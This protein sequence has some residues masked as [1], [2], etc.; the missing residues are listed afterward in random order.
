MNILENT[1]AVVILVAL[2]LFLLWLT[3]TV[4]YQM[5]KCSNCRRQAE[6]HGERYGGGIIPKGIPPHLQSKS[7]RSGSGTTL[8]ANSETDFDAHA[9]DVT[10][11]P[12][13][14]RKENLLAYRFAEAE[15][16]IQK[17][18]AITFRLH[19]KGGDLWEARAAAEKALAYGI[20][21][22]TGDHWLLARLL[23][24]LGYIELVHRDLFKALSHFEAASAIISEWPGKSKADEDCIS[25]NLAYLKRELGF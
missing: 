5:R 13:E 7:T 20:K 23:T 11:E 1:T 4:R 10:D 2:G 6:R 24:R 19:S 8:P 21:H 17:L 22:L 12:A 16:E 9:D 14:P 3:V 18:D 15:A 25:A